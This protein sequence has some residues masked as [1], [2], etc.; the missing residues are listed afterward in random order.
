MQNPLK[1][2]PPLSQYP[3]WKIR[4]FLDHVQS[5]SQ[6]AWVCGVEIS[7][8]EKNLKFQGCHNDK[9]RILY[10]QEGN[11]FQYNAL[12]SNGYTFAFYFRNNP[13]PSK[14]T[15]QGLS[16]LHAWVVALFNKLNEK[17]HHCGMDNLY[18]LARF[19]Q[20]AYNHPMQVRRGLKLKPPRDYAGSCQSS[21]TCPGLIA[22]SVYDTI[23]I[24]FLSMRCKEI[25]WVE[26][27]TR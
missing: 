7:I 16:P 3:N 6:E 12:C 15:Q 10:K 26:C 23:L 21:T 22:V 4:E 19:C 9:L 8:D 13:P 1:S 18:N 27:T 24:H 25:K 5:I 20:A 2:V 11:S 14:Y 17:F